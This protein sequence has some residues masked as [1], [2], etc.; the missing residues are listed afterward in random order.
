[1]NEAVKTGAERR[2]NQRY[3]IDLPVQVTGSFGAFSGRACDICRDAVWIE[4]GPEVRSEADVALTLEF[5]GAGAPLELGGR[6]IRIGPGVVAPHGMA[7]LFTG[8]TPAAATVIDFFIESQ[9]G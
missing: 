4:G 3:T 8:V 2:K 6:I 9:G 7:V 1:M 5:P